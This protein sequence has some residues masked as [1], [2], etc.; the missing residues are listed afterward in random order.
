MINVGSVEEAY[1]LARR[2]PGTVE[3]TGMP[4]Y[5]PEI[6]G[7]P[8]DSH[9][10]LFNDGGIVGRAAAA[11]RIVGVPGVNTAYLCKILREAVY[12][13]RFRTF[14]AAEAVVGLDKDFTVRAKL[15]IPEGFENNL[16]NWMLNFQFMTPEVRAFYRSSRVIEGEGNILVYA[17][18]YW[19]HPDFPL[20]LAFFSPE[21]NCAAVLGMRYF[22]EL[23]KA[24]LTLGWGT[25]ARHG[26]ASCHGGLKRFT[27]KDGSKFV[28]AVFGLSG[29][30]K[31]T[32]THAKHDGKYDI[33]VLHDDAFVV[34]VKDKYAIAM[35]PTYFDKLQDYPIGCDANKYLLTVQNCGVTEDADGKL[36]A[37]T[38][39]VR[40][41]NGR[42]IKSRLWTA[43]R[44]D[45]IDEPLNAI[46]WLMKDPTLP[47]MLKLTGASLASV[48]GATLATK[49]TTAEQLAKGV[50]PNALVIESYANPFRTYPLAMDY[51]RFKKL[52]EDG[53]DCYI[54]NTGEFMGKKVTKENTF[55]AL[56][57][58]VDGTAQF[59]PFGNIPG[60]EYLPVE[61]FTVDTKD[62]A[63]A[64]ALAKRMADRLEFVTSRDTFNGGV[65]KLPA[66]AVDAIK[67]VID[68]LK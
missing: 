7:L 43:N 42:A 61:G 36:L 56:E 33:M 1:E 68:A 59:K 21:Q 16:L 2:S 19:T 53:V 35:E 41:G 45:R 64:E 17:D 28:L 60:I 18:P 13:A 62:P 44:V 20:G 37:V 30:G 9:V 48:M 63:Y 4:I 27:K 14:Y 26:Y 32:I 39:D 25:A 46:C 31:S 40:S 47:P 52:I 67:A 54:L 38:E 8:K 10:L 66:D 6:Q 50:D 3:L 23:K 57:A 5:E 58:V 55:A 24:T 65:D 15:M 49:R 51:E 22:G 34:N 12:E 11:R 29:S